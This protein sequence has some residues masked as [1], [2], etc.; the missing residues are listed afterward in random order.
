[1]TGTT[2]KGTVE[3]E[4]IILSVTD[5]RLLDGAFLIIAE[6]WGPSAGYR[7]PARIYGPDGVLV[8][9]GG[10][11]DCPAATKDQRLRLEAVLTPESP[12]A[13]D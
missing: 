5:I 11:I 2:P 6:G 12:R 1:M 3:Y 10:T 9:D 7:G 8:Q 13:L 4:D